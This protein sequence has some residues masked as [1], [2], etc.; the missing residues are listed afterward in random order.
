MNGKTSGTMR[1]LLKLNIRAVLWTEF[2]FRRV[3]RYF[4]VFAKKKYC[5]F[6]AHPDIYIY[7]IDVFMKLLIENL[8]FIISTNFW[9]YEIWHYST[10][11]TLQPFLHVVLINRI[12]GF[13][14]YITEILR[15]GIRNFIF[16]FRLLLS[17]STA[18]FIRRWMLFFWFVCIA[19]FS[20]VAGSLH[21]N[22]MCLSLSF[23]L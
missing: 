20:M 12:I 10:I 3:I 13:I 4:Q 5:V 17:T 19:R 14:N 22:F 1:N 18:F 9:F 11:N 8:K 6:L 23:L 7:S 21:R 15:N 16:L 2:L